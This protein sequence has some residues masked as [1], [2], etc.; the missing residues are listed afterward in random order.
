MQGTNLIELDIA[1]R[2]QA[3]RIANRRLMNGKSTVEHFVSEYRKSYRKLT[4]RGKAFKKITN[5]NNA[6]FKKRFDEER[7]DSKGGQN[8]GN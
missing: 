4:P 2:L 8:A 1:Y 3:L 5:I 7:V 6:F